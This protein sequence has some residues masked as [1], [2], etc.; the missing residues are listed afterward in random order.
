MLESIVLM[1]IQNIW[2]LVFKKAGYLIHFQVH[3]WGGIS[4]KGPTPLAIFEGIL[5]SG[6]YTSLLETH[7]LPFI[8]KHFPQRHR[9]QQDNDPKHTSKHTKAWLKEKN[10]NWW[11]TPPESPG[12]CIYNVNLPKPETFKHLIYFTLCG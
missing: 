6:C 11:A 10:I 3:V 2:I 7:L 5:V 8:R 12:K 4:K 1:N 9:F